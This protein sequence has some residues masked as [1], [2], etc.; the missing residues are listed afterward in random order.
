M[1]VPW[2]SDLDT[3]I[4]DIDVQHRRLFRE[5]AVMME[6]VKQHR[7]KTAVSAFIPFITQHVEQHFA[8]EE[9][10]M[11]GRGYPDYTAHR[12]AHDE[13]RKSV[14]DLVSEYEAKGYGPLIVLRLGMLLDDWLRRHIYGLDIPMASW[15]RKNPAQPK[16]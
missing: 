10:I 13:L 11:L 16:G 9:G 5:V 1:T 3:G 4:G 2:D 7:S 6:A 12:I 8:T 14:G 15:L